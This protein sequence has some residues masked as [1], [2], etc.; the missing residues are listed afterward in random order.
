MKKTLL[1]L[2]TMMSIGLVANSQTVSPDI[3]FDDEPGT[4]N[5]GITSDGQ[6]YYTCNGGKAP[7]G[8][9]K[10]R[11]HPFDG[12]GLHKGFSNDDW[13]AIRERAYAGRGGRDA[14]E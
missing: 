6:F 3:Y 5:M 10:L 9:I 4:H 11:R 12:K 7:D 14:Q 8:K 2:I 13:R 1:I